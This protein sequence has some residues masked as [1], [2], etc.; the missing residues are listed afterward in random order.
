MYAT[1]VPGFPIDRIAIPIAVAVATKIL[2]LRTRDEITATLSQAFPIPCCSG[3]SA[4]KRGWSGLKPSFVG[5]GVMPPLYGL[6]D[7]YPVI[8]VQKRRN[9]DFTW[10]GEPPIGNC[11]LIVQDYVARDLLVVTTAE[12]VAD[13]TTA[14]AFACAVPVDRTRLR[15]LL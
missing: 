3:S 15:P 9:L 1:S 13:S 6:V 11:K 2:A 7:Q 10:A 12:A 5:I 14:A 4:R 8:E